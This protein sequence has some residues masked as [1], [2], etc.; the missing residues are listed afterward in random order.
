[1]FRRVLI[2]NRG[3]IACRVIRAVKA[4]GAEAVA[5]YSDAD[6]GALHVKQADTAVHLGPAA[7]AD[8][9]LHIQRVLDAAK[10]AGCDA[11]HP[12]YGFLSENATFIRRCAEAGIA[13]VGP[14]AAAIDSMPD[15]VAARTALGRAGLPLVPGS[16]PVAD[17][18]VALREAERIGYP[19]MVKAASGGGGIGMSRVDN[20]D[21][22]KSAV[23]TART[24]AEKSFG[25]AT[26]YLEK[27]VPS[28]H[29]VE[30]QVLGD[31]R[32]AVHVWDREC[33]IQRRFQKI[34]EEA[35]APYAGAPRDAMDAAAAGAVK[36]L[37]YVNAGTVECL[38]AGDGSKNWYFLEINR[39]IQ[40]EHPVTEAITG[41]DLVQLQLKIAADG[42][43][44]ITQADVKHHGHAIEL[45]VCAEDP[46]RFFPSPGTITK[47]RPPE[48]DGLRV[49]AGVEVG[50]SV[51]MFYDP[52]L[53]KVVVWGENREQAIER[54][55]AAAKS[56]VVEGVK[57]NLPLHQRILEDE[58]FRRGDTPTSYL[59]DLMKR[60]KAS[61]AIK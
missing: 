39:R 21:S 50:S 48:G 41:L 3:E 19:V 61:G 33:S 58:V 42:K 20:P 29:H 22:L 49:D 8:S 24:R 11:I 30:V 18:D 16:E 59:D 51:P 34:V 26:V 1:M 31:G 6:Q 60:L 44:P 13:F 2:A 57:T 53:A 25:D 55:L 38:V 5:V 54:A 46:W 36:K 40:V 14:T 27:F 7:P 32:D 45:R 37:G 15:K 10:H 4:L 12:G 17:A 56:M 47:W 35:R 28:P 9:Y 23:E 43:L 52:L